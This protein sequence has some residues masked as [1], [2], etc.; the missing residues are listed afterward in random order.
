M[1]VCSVCHC[2]PWCCCFCCVCL[3]FCTNIITS[4]N[5]QPALV[6]APEELAVEECFV[7]GA[8]CLCLCLLLLFLAQHLRCLFFALPTYYCCSIRCSCV[9]ASVFLPQRHRVHSEGGGRGVCLV[10]YSLPL[11]LANSQHSA[12]MQ[13]TCAVCVCVCDLDPPPYSCT[14]APLA[15][16]HACR[17][18]EGK[19]ISTR[20]LYTVLYLMCL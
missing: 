2:L 1:C 8:V 5:H 14:L 6:G 7:V 17:S 16:A 12:A 15:A 4:N 19:Q 3:S 11:T 10:S 20:V 18:E 13:C 9:V